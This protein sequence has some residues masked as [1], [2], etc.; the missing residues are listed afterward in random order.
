MGVKLASAVPG[1]TAKATVRRL[2]REDI[3]GGKDHEQIPTAH[4]DWLKKTTYR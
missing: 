2:S 4:K 1:N 3:F